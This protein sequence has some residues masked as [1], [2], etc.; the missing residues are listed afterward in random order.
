MVDEETAV[1]EPKQD[2]TDEEQEMAKLKEAISVAVEDIGTLRRKLTIT[3]PKGT[4]DEKRG[5]Q[6]GE[7][8]RDSI[9]PGFRKGHA[10]MPLIEKRF[11]SEV[12]GQL[13]S[14]LLSRSYL[15]AV[16]KE[17][18]KTI[19]DPLVWAKDMQS[20]DPDAQK[21]MSVEQAFDAITLPTDG[22]FVYS[23]E[24]EVRPEFKLP[25]LEGIEI[26]QPKIEIGKAQ[27][28]EQ[29]DR[30][31]AMRG[32]YAPVP[33]DK[34]QED[35]LVVCD[36][37][38]AVGDKVL[39]EEKNAQLAARPQ[40][41]GGIA[42]EE[43]GE[44]LK[45]AKVGESKKTS[46]Q[47]PDDYED[48]SV[49]GKQA[50][51][52]LTVAD[53]KRLVLPEVNAE[54]LS[55]LGFDSKKELEDWI[56]SNL[57]ARMD[58]DIRRSKREQVYQYLHDNAKFDLPEGISRRQTDRIA[59]RRM[60]ELAQRGV[61]EAEVMKQADAIKVGAQKDAVKD[62]KLHFILES[63]AEEWEVDVSEDE[64]NGQIAAIA[65][66]QNRRF[67]RVRDE[68]MRNHS[69]S[70]LYTHVRD[71]KIVDRIIDQANIVEA[72]ESQKKETEK[73]S[74]TSST[75]KKKKTTSKKKTAKKNTGK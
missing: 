18:L 23:C 57:E 54:F 45:G 25:S 27:I 64:I 66:R 20:D 40:R 72:Q 62:L 14:Q 65:Q 59:A 60:L 70:S 58:E 26:R 41:Y 49:R 48:E 73:K 6:F 15:A 38:V 10:P 21:L 67:D 31:R 61:P 50:D 13:S 24:I 71:E 75:P 28:N 3:V 32:H 29:I 55:D 1:E 30:L 34:I 8:K 9:V 33:D 2:M 5:E 47:V 39:F 12:N 11:G 17:D 63:I 19:G 16:E 68:L 74:A 56:T 52:E 37:K 43:L 22:D 7:L 42:F 4:V 44:A 46:G 36:L 51:V 35:D 69:M 53:I